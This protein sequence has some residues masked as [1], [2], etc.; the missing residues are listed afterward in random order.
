MSSTENSFQISL[1]Q[2]LPFL[3]K[4]YVPVGM[5]QPPYPTE[6]VL[7]DN[8]QGEYA[9]KTDTALFFPVLLQE[10][11]LTVTKVRFFTA[12]FN[13]WS[14]TPEVDNSVF[15]GFAL[16]K[17]IGSD[18]W[19]LVAKTPNVPNF[20]CRNLEPDQNAEFFTNEIAFEMPV[21]L[22][23]GRYFVVMQNKLASSPSLTSLENT[24]HSRSIREYPLQNNEFYGVP[25]VQKW[26]NPLFEEPP[27]II[28][29]SVDVQ[30]V[31]SNIDGDALMYYVKVL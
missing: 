27:A 2:N 19:Q 22:T 11:M 10:S 16:Y 17:D 9:T 21:T 24:L 12:I 23:Q 6:I 3:L 26:L 5:Y 15:N 7:F 30:T 1:N 20:L 14:E 31:V 29:P 13:N 18:Q 25:M 4:A 28:T 8:G